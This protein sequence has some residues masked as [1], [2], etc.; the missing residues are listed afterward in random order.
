M[1][2]TSQQDTCPAACPFK[3]NGCYADAGPLRRLWN[4]LSETA[5]GETF[6]N[7]PTGKI[8]V[9]SI[10]DLVEAIR[11]N[12]RA[13]WRHNQAGD[14]AHDGKGAIDRDALRAIVVANVNAEGRGFTY[15]HHGVL[16]S[17]P[18][19]EHN[20]NLISAANVAGFTIN[21][22]G[23][24]LAHADKLADTKAGPVVVVLT[25]TQTADTVTPKGR[26]VVVCPATQ[27]D[28]VTCM[29]CGMCQLA[30]RD[31]IIGFPAHG[32]SKAK[33]DKVAA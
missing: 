7:G 28:D 3:A 24:T 20:R 9:G 19:A 8:R 11:K 5:V 27:R 26:K 12:G 29:S 21:L 17:T 2:T 33:A 6:T 14:L 23:N 16:G 22:S 31:F 30:S 25:S 15:T 32:T 18:I 10:A 1:V 13:L 4:K